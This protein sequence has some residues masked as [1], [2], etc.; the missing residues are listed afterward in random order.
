MAAFPD[1]EGV[2]CYQTYI[3]VWSKSDL[4]DEW[5]LSA[6]LNSP[7]A[8]AFVSTR[9]GKTDITMETLKLIPAPHFTVSQREK[10]KFLI[11]RYQ[12]SLRSTNTSIDEERLLKEIDAL[13]V[14]GYRM[15]PRLERQLLDFFRGQPRPTAHPFNEYVPKDC[16]VF[17]SLSEYLSPD[18]AA[19]TSGELIKRLAKG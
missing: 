7:V 12:D 13:V 9:E 18:F 1:T 14:D 3:G 10:L 17:F 6:I 15:P 19:A 2:A 5:L 4:Y 8:N 16:E 11:K